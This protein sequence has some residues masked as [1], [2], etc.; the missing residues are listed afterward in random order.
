[1]CAKY[2]RRLLAFVLSAS[3][4]MSTAIGEQASSISPTLTHGAN[5]TNERTA[6]WLTLDQLLKEL[7]SEANAQE[8]D[9]NKLRSELEQSKI[10]IERLSSLSAQLKTQ[11][12]SLDGSIAEER[13]VTAKSYSAALLQRNIAIISA[14]F[15]GLAAAIIAI[16]K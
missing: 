9:L 11:L 8:S 10:E 7:E 16:V 5:N 13:E 14:L 12:T 3:L 1:M 15:F 2:F 6:Y 4:V